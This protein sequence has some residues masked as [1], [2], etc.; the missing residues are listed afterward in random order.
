MQRTRIALA[1]ALALVLLLGTTQAAQAGDKPPAVYWMSV[2]TEV[3]GATGATG[4]A[5]AGGP[6]MPSMGE[7]LMGGLTG[8]MGSTQTGAPGSGGAHRSLLL[9]LSA[10]GT[11]S[12]PKADE[13][14]PP[15]QK[16]G[17]SLPL[18]TPAPGKLSKYETSEEEPEPEKPKGR[19][20]IYWG[21]SD[22]VRPGQPKVLDMASATPQDFAR[23]FRSVG[24]H[25]PRGPHMMSG[26]TYARWPNDKD[27]QAVPQDSSLLGS[28]SVKANYA[29]EIRFDIPR[30]NDFMEPVVFSEIKD[31]LAE[32]ISVHWKPVSNAVGYF[33]MAMGGKGEN[34]TVIW[35][36]SETPHMGW[37]LMDFV[38]TGEVRRL[39]KA[40]VIMPP[41][42]T[43][44]QIPKGIFKEA[45]GGMLQFI[46]YGPDL[47]VSYP[48]RPKNAP[49]G[50]NPDWVAKVRLKST[51]MALLGQA[52]HG[53]GQ[54]GTEQE[55]QPEKKD[56]MENPIKSLKG[57]F[58]F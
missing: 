54:T 47:D 6:G 25:R 3:G 45:E 41:S 40:R 28:H 44:C 39:T 14:I 4:G 20:S 58:G 11:V 26:R 12:D 10:P 38:P 42:T 49:I 32:P 19:I 50:W 18:I 56:S 43:T 48:P 30:Q 46:A 2:S 55:S 23:F 53:D 27:N 22:K 1:L 24:I 37:D 36:S 5:G 31:D 8:S 15:G 13:F 9:Q 51:N 52:M 29:P 7:M 35:V 34:D 17:E 21:C 16:M 57:I 33:A